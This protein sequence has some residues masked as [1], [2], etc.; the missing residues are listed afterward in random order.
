MLEIEYLEYKIHEL[1][2]IVMCV[3]VCLF[4]C[5][6]LLKNLKIKKLKVVKKSTKSGG[7][8]EFAHSPLPPLSSL[9]GDIIYIVLSAKLFP[10][11]VKK[12]PF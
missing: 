10:L 4:L 9:L 5:L 2:V 11:A 1:V 8:K 3:C 12:R 7:V 6:C